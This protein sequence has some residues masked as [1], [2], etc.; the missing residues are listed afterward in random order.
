MTDLISPRAWRTTARGKSA[1][2]CRQVG[3]QQLDP[4]EAIA[5]HLMPLDD[6]EERLQQSYHQLT[7]Y[8]AMGWLGR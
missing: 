1:L 8:K 4:N 7:W 6:L 5:V 3:E 2:G